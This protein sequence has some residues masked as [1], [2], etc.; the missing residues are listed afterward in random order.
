[1][2]VSGASSLAGVLRDFWAAARSFSLE[3]GPLGRQHALALPLWVEGIA[4]ARY[5]QSTLHHISACADLCEYVGDSLLVAG[6]HP[7]AA[8]DDEFQAPPCP[9]LLLRSFR[10]VEV[11]EFT[12]EAV[13]PVQSEAREV[14]YPGDV[15]YPGDVDVL[16]AT[17]AW[18]EGV[19]VKMRVCPFSSTADRAGLPAGGVSYP[20]TRAT[21]G[22]E[23][24]ERFWEQVVG[25]GVTEERQIS[26]VLLLAPRFALHC[27][28]GFDAFANTLN[29]ALTEL[30][31]EE[32]IQLVFFHPGYAFRDGK[33]RLGIDGAANY[34]R[35]S[36]YPMINL[37]RTPQVR[38]AQKG[39]PTGS[40]YTTNER[41]LETVGAAVLQQMLELRDWA[42][43]YGV[44]FAGH[45]DNTWK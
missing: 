24:Y 26:T 25:L 45:E 21:S 1:M 10:Q 11:S 20:I 6:R 4:D 18:V 8:P 34:A 12:S 29:A 3:E 35:R 13:L 16:A 7:A 37:L 17:R 15:R 14:G 27:P 9:V 33:E 22:E 44:E 38:I 41:N 42:G 28:D 19:I 36:P 31:V 43:V 32:Q 5:F 30:R 2:A 40:V 39:I 23:V